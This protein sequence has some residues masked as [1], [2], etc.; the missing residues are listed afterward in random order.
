MGFPIFGSIEATQVFNIL[1]ILAA[2]TLTVLVAIFILPGKKRSGLN[3]FFK[4]L[5]DLFNFKY[6]IIETVLRILYVLATIYIVVLGVF[7][8]FAF[9]DSY[10]GFEWYGY[11]G[12]IMIIVGPIAI[13]LAYEFLMMAIL[14]VKNVMQINNKIKGDGK[15]VDTF[16]VPNPIAT[17]APKASNTPASTF[18]S[19]CG[20]RLD[21]NGDCPNCK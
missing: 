7:N 15:E 5:H 11:Y 1:A 8:L 2:I 19:E 4:F 16:D 13:R 18:C 6:L 3:P 9:Y 14:L 21:E 12:L 20:T 10:Y 17:I